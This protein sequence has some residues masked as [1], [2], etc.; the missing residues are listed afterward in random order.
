MIFL[1]RTTIGFCTHLSED[2]KIVH[3]CCIARIY[4]PILALAVVFS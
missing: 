4:I 1:I 2:I 3:T